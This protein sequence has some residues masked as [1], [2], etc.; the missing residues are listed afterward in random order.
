[1]ELNQSMEPEPPRIEF[2]CDYPVKVLGRSCLEFEAVVLEI[3]ERHAP[4]F[5]RQRTRTTS[6]GM[7]RI[8]ML[9]L[10]DYSIGGVRWRGETIH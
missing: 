10:F 3:F 8:L 7:S 6:A 1:M 5:D 4:G 9:T 2:P